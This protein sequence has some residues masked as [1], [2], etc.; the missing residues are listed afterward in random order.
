[1]AAVAEAI[2]LSPAYVESVASFYD[3]LYLQPTGH[4]GGVGV[5]DPLVHA[6]RLGRAAGAHLRARGA[7]PTRAARARTARSPCRRPSA[8]ATA[9]AR[10]ASRWTPR[11]PAARCRSRRRRRAARRAARE[12]P[13][14][15]ALAVEPCRCERHLPPAPGGAPLTTC[16]TTARAGGY[17]G[18]RKVARATWTATRSLYAFTPLR[19][20]RP[21]RRRL[22][23][24]HARR[25]SSRR[26][27][28]AGL[29]RVQ[30]RR[31]RAGHL[32]GPRDHGGQPA[33]SS[34]R[35]SPS[36]ATRSARRAPTSTSA[37]STSTR[38][39]CSTR[40]IAQARAA[41]L[42]GKDVLG[43]GFDFDITAPPRRGR[44][45]LR[46]GD[47]AAREPRGQARPAAAEAAVPGRRRPLR[48]AR[49]SSTTSRRSPTLPL[50]RRARRRLVRRASAPRRAPGTKLFSSRAT[51]CG[52]ATT[53]SSMGETTL[54][55]LIYDIA[56]R[57]SAPGRDAQGHH[58]GGGSR[59]NVLGAEALDTPLDYESRRRGRHPARAR[60]A[61]S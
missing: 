27:G 35:G 60:P 40:R 31:E 50:D 3:R 29:R 53:R 4:A 21:R 2:G 17:E 41:G 5:H 46:R 52:R 20:A 58:A 8:W 18:L 54:R 34:S 38:R 30:R 47:G 7:R 14:G 26:I 1:M 51:W 10:P 59:V 15:S 43:S 24:G 32:Q 45:H 22:P 25:A 9:T 16:R 44:L 42:L 33:S 28:A 56:R 11:R 36:P 57:R 49:R 12:P 6:A 37:A 39:A 61:A 13:P 19:P 48:L 23:D 55:E